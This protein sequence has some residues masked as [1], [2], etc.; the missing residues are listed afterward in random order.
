MAG[1]VGYLSYFYTASLATSRVSSRVY[2]EEPRRLTRAENGEDTPLSAWKKNLLKKKL[3]R[4]QISK[5]K[6]RRS[7]F[8]EFASRLPPVKPTEIVKKKILPSSGLK[9]TVSDDINS[10]EQVRSDLSDQKQTV[11][12]QLESLVPRKK[13]PTNI[14]DE[15]EIFS[16]LKKVTKKGGKK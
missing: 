3:E 2:S 12:D 7:I 11:F 13:T 14:K 15:E 4:L 8:G 6:N 9:K 16:R 10:K 1:G 5:S